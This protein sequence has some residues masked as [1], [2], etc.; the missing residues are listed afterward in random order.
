MD[1]RKRNFALINPAQCLLIWSTIDANDPKPR[2][3]RRVF[4]HVITH[5]ETNTGVV[6]LTHE[7]IAELI[8][9]RSSEVSSAMG[10]L[11]KIGAV[12]R[13]RVKTPGTR[14][15]G[16]TQ[17]R[18]NPNIAWSGSL[19]HRAEAAHVINLAD[20]R[21]SRFGIPEDGDNIA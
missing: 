14:G 12:I 9:V 13:E 2:T 19:K 15:P 7:E 4:D 16:K 1:D 6:T 3:T 11:E 8:G 20:V 21:K 5:I 18:I 10:R 17:H